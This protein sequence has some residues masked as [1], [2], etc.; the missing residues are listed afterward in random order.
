MTG[1][2]LDYPYFKEQYKIIS[3]DLIKQKAIDADLKAKQQINITG[4][5]GE[6]ATIFFI[7]EEAKEYILGFS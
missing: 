3:I 2:L 1:S 4:N 7:I 5:L 6:E